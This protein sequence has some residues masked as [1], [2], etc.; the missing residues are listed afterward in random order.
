[1]FA[2]GLGVVILLAVGLYTVRNFGR[3]TLIRLPLPAKEKLLEFYDRFEEGV[4]AVNPRQIPFLAL[5]TVLIWSTEAI[6][7]FLVIEALGFNDVFLGISGAFF[8][9]L[10]ASLLTAIPFTPAGLGI[11][12]LGVVGILTVIYGVNTADAAAITVVDRSIS[13]LS[14]II[15]GSIAYLLSSKTKGGPRRPIETEVAPA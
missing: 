5:L 12:E 3:R 14:I 8:V 10:A 15:L 4:F 6:R 7:L 1:V 2:I 11:V 9:A 13:V